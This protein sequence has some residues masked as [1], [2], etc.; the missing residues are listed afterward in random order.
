M[1]YL[2]DGQEG[3]RMYFDFKH[4]KQHTVFYNSK[5]Q[6]IE[7]QK[8]PEILYPNDTGLVM[9]VSVEEWPNTDFNA[10]AKELQKPIKR[11]KK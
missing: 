1:H 5:E 8:Y 7:I 3:H 9:R 4:R 10:L 11:A 2:L 6:T